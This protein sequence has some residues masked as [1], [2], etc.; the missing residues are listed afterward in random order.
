MDQGLK[1]LE[2][3]EI[4]QKTIAEAK[5]RFQ[6]NGHIYIFWGTLNAICATAQFVLEQQHVPYAFFIWLLTIPGSIYT[7]VYYARKGKR[8]RQGKN[9]ISSILTVA[10]I[11]IGVN[12]F[13]LGFGFWP[14]LGTAFVPVVVMFLSIYA[15]VVAKA[16]Q[17]QKMFIM[18]LVTNILGF[19]L[20][21][22][23]L[24]YQPLGLAL[25]SIFLLL[26][27]GIILNRMNK[28]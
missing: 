4:I 27:P 23:D 15:M 8:Q 20:F 9:V 18:A 5:L 21:F 13:I 24:A 25:A 3:L 2:S 19:G 11:I 17:F 12:I 28:N 26:I 16:L 1:P 10:G 7:S 22:V 14:F 6:D